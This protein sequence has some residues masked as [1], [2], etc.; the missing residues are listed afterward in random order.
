[1][2]YIL[3]PI[4]LVIMKPNAN[5]CKNNSIIYMFGEMHFMTSNLCKANCKVSKCYEIDKLLEEMFN[6]AQ[7]DN[8][9]INFLVEVSPGIQKMERQEYLT[10]YYFY[11]KFYEEFTGGS[12]KFSN[13]FFNRVD[14]RSIYYYNLFR[15]N[16]FLYH[17]FEESIESEIPEQID[18]F[19][20]YIGILVND[21]IYLKL[22]KIYIY[23]DN[24]IND[25]DYLLSSYNNPYF[26]IYRKINIERLKQFH[27]IIYEGKSYSLT[28]FE[29]YKLKKKNEYAYNELDKFIGKLLVKENKKFIDVL[30]HAYELLLEGSVFASDNLVL[31]NEKITILLSLVLDVK[32]LSSYMNGECNVFNFFIFY[33][34]YKHIARYYKFFKQ[35][36]FDEIAYF[37][38]PA[39]QRFGKYTQNCVYVYG[40]NVVENIK[41][42]N[43]MQVT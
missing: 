12:K 20:D 31:A 37:R 16:N 9:T 10:F 40:N 8:K 34:G 23:S 33:F 2:P 17:D 36:G 4:S 32:V 15:E 5:I 11:E 19:I 35:L 21:D 42:L 26:E 38:E 41:N 24:F 43:F 30:L 28:S 7:K 13:V 22:V 6:T 1:M 27:E 18:P 25:I 14:N 3:G 29:F 39:Y